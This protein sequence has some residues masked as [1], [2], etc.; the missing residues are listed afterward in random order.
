[1]WEAEYKGFILNHKLL[2]LWLQTKQCI[3]HQT[4]M[5]G[6]FFRTIQRIL[7]FCQGNTYWSV[8]AVGCHN[9]ANILLFSRDG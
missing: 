2:Q 3:M 9:Y 8:K 7:F 4:I 1:M 5:F 6:F